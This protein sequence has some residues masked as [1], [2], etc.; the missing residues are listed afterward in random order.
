VTAGDPTHRG[1]QLRH[2]KDV[3]AY[4]VLQH[5]ARAS[6]LLKW[7]IQ[8]CPYHT[9][10]SYL[11]MDF[12]RFVCYSKSYGKL[13]LPILQLN[14]IAEHSSWLLMNWVTRLWRCPLQCHFRPSLPFVWRNPT[15]RSWHTCL[16]KKPN[17]PKQHKK[18]NP[19]PRTLHIKQLQVDSDK[20]NLVAL[21][22]QVELVQISA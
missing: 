6:H 16:T 13:L 7:R 4:M 8:L 21:F 18:T 11:Q 3:P 10:E 15:T 17:Q 9:F 14:C 19:N 12:Y 20:I 2:Q 22:R 5:R 1:L